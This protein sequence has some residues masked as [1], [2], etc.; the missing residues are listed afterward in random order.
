M[1][2]TPPRLAFER[3]G[4]GFASRFADKPH[5]PDESVSLPLTKGEREGFLCKACIKEKGIAFPVVK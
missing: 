2:I 1:D 3:G 4:E 5:K